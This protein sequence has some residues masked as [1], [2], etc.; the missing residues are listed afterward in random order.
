MQHVAK[1]LGF[2]VR[3]FPE[4]RLVKAVLELA[5]ETD[6]EYMPVNLPVAQLGDQTANG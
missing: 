3:Y 6:R 4:E 1:K 5:V 2:S